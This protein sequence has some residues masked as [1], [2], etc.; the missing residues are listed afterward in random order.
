[1]PRER[2]V[3]LTASSRAEIDALLDR[4][5]PEAVARRDPAAAYD[6]V[7][8]SLRAGTTRAQWRAGVVPAP[9]Y[10]PAGKRFHGWRLV[11]S[12]R[13]S[14]SIELTLQPGAAEQAVGAFVVDLRRVGSRWLVD[15]IYERAAY[16]TS[17]RGGTSTTS[18]TATSATERPVG[19]SAGG[20]GWSGS[21]SPSACSH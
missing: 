7:T 3:P 16:P 19:G 14:A 4:F 1:M 5:V 9:T 6:L 2:R 20:S 17:A 21:S 13:N 15:G 10:D 12:F 8:P 18:P 11:Y